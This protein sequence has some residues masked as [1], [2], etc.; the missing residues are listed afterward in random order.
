MKTTP[1][2]APESAP[3]SAS[4]GAHHE[5]GLQKKKRLKQS[6]PSPDTQPSS[7][8]YSESSGEEPDEL[9]T[10][11]KPVQLH[12]DVHEELYGLPT[13]RKMSHQDSGDI[14]T[15]EPEKTPGTVELE[16]SDDDESLE[17]GVST[18]GTH[19][20]HSYHVVFCWDSVH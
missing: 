3:A 7:E 8:Y 19:K 20:D 15:T 12:E 6:F 1:K 4:S 5:D 11:A 13:P 2:S 10:G 9:D 14:A 17:K 16:I 18:T